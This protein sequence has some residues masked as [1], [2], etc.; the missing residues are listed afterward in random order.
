MRYTRLGFFFLLLT[1]S[2]LLMSSSAQACSC[3]QPGPPAAEFEQFDA[4]FTGVVTAF[5][6]PSDFDRKATLSLMKVWKGDF[7]RLDKIYTGPNSA[8]CGYEFQVGKSYVIYAWET[9]AG[10]FRTNICTRT[11]RIQDAEEDLAYLDELEPI[12]IGEDA[13]CCG[14]PLSSGDAIMAGFFACFLFWRR[15]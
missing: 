9:D 4:V 13:G 14:S 11:A 12:Y 2:L 6:Q 15:R 10:H 3:V 5:T 1:V 7:N 8:A